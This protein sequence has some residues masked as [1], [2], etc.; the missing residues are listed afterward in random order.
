M[1]AQALIITQ[2]N[3]AP[4]P[5]RTRPNFASEIKRKAALELF[6]EGFGYKR[7]AAAL[8]LPT[9][10]V[11]DWARAWRKGRFHIRLN[12]NQY[13]Y[14]AKTK[15]LVLDMRRRGLPW[16]EI[17][18][19]T[20]VPT[21]TCRSWYAKAEANPAAAVKLYADRAAERRRSSIR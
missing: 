18:E 17:A 9:N 21:S 7:T 16:R 2:Q 4:K 20:G 15:L 13:R 12:A 14:S 11:R 6:Q 5:S 3:A 8:G 19:S 10:T 1:G